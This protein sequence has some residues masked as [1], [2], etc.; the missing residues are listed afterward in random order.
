MPENHQKTLLKVAVI[1]LLLLALTVGLSFAQLGKFGFLVALL[2]AA[3][4]AVLVVWF[5]MELRV[6]SET[7]WIM[8]LLGFFWLFILIAGTLA[9]I[10][11][12]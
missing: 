7:V 8:S 5:F 6:G 9:D 12:A 10:S 4:K 1:L 2:I 11:N 3:A